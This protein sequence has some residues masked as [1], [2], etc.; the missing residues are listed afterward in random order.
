MTDL[1]ETIDFAAIDFSQVMAEERGDGERNM[2]FL[3]RP[4]T[5]VR[6]VSVVEQDVIVEG[7]VFPPRPETIKAAVAAYQELVAIYGS[8]NVI[9]IA[10]FKDRGAGVQELNEA[11]RVALGYDDPVPRVGELLMIT[12]NSS[13]RDRLNGERYRAVAVAVDRKIIKAR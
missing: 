13:N 9:A 1:L 8:E 12:K 10:P 5:G 6:F 4:R 3:L 7:R 11:I 2:D